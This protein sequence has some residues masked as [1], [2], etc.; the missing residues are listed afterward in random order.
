MPLFRTTALIVIF[1]F[2]VSLGTAAAPV[3][4]NAGTQDVDRSIKPGD[5]FYRYANGVPMSA[6]R[7]MDCTVLTSIVVWV[8]RSR[9]QCV[10]EIVEVK[11]TSLLGHA[12]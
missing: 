3:D 11:P 8:T 2:A 7:S 4:Q 12:G 9:C 1:A 5:D 10:A 6:C